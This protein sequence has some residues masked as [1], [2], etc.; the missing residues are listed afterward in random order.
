MPARYAPALTPALRRLLTT[1]T[2]AGAER[3]AGSPSPAEIDWLTA[4]ARGSANA[5][6][7]LSPHR[8]IH[9]LAAAASAAVAIPVLDEIARNPDAAVTDRVAA[10]RGLGR[11]ATSDAQALLLHHATGA[12]ARLQQAALASLGLF[13]DRSAF[14]A[15]GSVPQPAD[16]AT[17][18]QL[19]FTRAL[20]VH[21]VGLVDAHLPDTQGIRWPTDD[22]GR[23]TGIGLEMKPAN[24]TRADR[25]RLR[26]SIY[27]IRLAERAYALRCGNAQWSVFG[28]REL[29]P[30]ITADDRLFRR[31]WIVALLARWMRPDVTAVTQ[32]VVLSSPAGCTVRLQVFRA[33]GELMYAGWGEPRGTGLYVEFSD[34]DRPQTAP[35]ILT[36]VLD[37]DGVRLETAFMAGT[38][39]ALRGAQPVNPA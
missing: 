2:E 27:G 3:S 21:R 32:Y 34:V 22:A 9:V 14:D 24:A 13:A 10:L 1:D 15:L 39:I 19:A 8:A 28:N 23:S 29:G 35:T 20:I 30:S 31:P 26:G 37:A 4:A 5:T 38:R 25:A 33:D 7:T 11:V 6:P 36:G 18:R 16:P 12:N 17:L